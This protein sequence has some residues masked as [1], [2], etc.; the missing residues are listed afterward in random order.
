[1]IWPLF[2]TIGNVTH[3]TYNFHPKHPKLVELLF[4]LY[5]TKNCWNKTIYCWLLFSNSNFITVGKA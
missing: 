2:S 5:K 1:M 3:L 4:L